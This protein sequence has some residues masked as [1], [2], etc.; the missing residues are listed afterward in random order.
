MRSL[1]I[2]SHKGGVGKTSIAVNIA[3]CLAK[4]GKNV[5]LLDIDLH[6]PS[7]MTFFR[8]Q[9]SWINKYF[10]GVEDAHNCLQNVA[11]KFNLPGTLLVGFADPTAESIQYVIRVDESVFVK[12]LQQLLKL[13]KILM[14][15]YKIDYLILDTSAGTHYTTINAILCVDAILFL[16]KLSNADI[17]GTSQMIAGLHKQL[18][19]KSMILANQIPNEFIDNVKVKNEFQQLIEKQFVIDIGDKVVKFLGWIPTDIELQKIELR[20]A[21]QSLRGEETLRTI[22]TLTQSNHIIA[23]IIISL[24]PIFF[25]D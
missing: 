6:G 17:I 13:K 19:T 2:L 16:V 9:V 14:N 23:Q 5:C 4:Q 12:M 21:L 25:G 10:F 8:P 15:E 7:I 1:A 18:K 22:Y 20:E 24:I 11:P 3:V